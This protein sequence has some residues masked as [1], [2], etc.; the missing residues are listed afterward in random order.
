M[1]VGVGSLADGLEAV[2]AG[3]IGRVP[4]AGGV[5]HRVGAQ[6]RWALAVLV[7]DFKGRVFAA[8]RLDLVEADAPNRNDACVG[9][10]VLRLSLVRVAS[11][12][13]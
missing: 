2:D 8:R 3:R 11:G 1:R 9:L 12:S 10:D 5:D 6:R 13:R 4:G 7:A